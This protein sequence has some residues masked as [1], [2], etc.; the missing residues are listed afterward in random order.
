LSL[1]N[2]FPSTSPEEPLH[3]EGIGPWAGAGTSIGWSA[4][5]PM[6]CEHQKSEAFPRLILEIERRE[7]IGYVWPTE[8][9]EGP[10]SRGMGPRIGRQAP[11]RPRGEPPPG[12]WELQARRSQRVA[13][14]VYQLSVKGDTVGSNGFEEGKFP[15]LS[16]TKARP[17][18]RAPNV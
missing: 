13:A 5:G 14:L 4:I 10:V 6:H 2:I 16:G 18:R 17:S 8:P 3:C 15:C 7:R 12:N 1:N 9:P 11:C